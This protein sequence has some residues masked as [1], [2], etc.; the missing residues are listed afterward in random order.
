[1]QNR[2]IL[3]LEKATQSSYIESLDWK[4]SPLKT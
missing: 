1:L 3:D 2:E 4:I